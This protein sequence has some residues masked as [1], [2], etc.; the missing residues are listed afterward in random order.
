MKTNLIT[1][2]FL[3]MSLSHIAQ[4][5][6]WDIIKKRLKEVYLQNPNNDSITNYLNKLNVNGTFTDINYSSSNTQLKD[7]AYNLHVK[8]TKEL[9]MAYLNQNNEYYTNDSLKKAYNKA[10]EY[11]MDIGYLPKNNWYNHIGYPT[12]V[13]IGHLLIGDY[14]YTEMPELYGKIVDYLNWRYERRAIRY[15][16]ATDVL[17]TIEIHIPHIVIDKNTF[18]LN[19]LI[20]EIL[21]QIEIADPNKKWEVKYLGGKRTY[22]RNSGIEADYSFSAHNRFGRQTYHSGYGIQYI[23]SLSNFFYFFDG[24]SYQLPEWA[25]NNFSKYLVY[26]YS[27]AFHNKVNDNST[28]GRGITRN[29]GISSPFQP[30]NYLKTSP[31]LKSKLQSLVNRMK[32]G[33]T[34]SD[35]L[36]G[37]KFFWRT[38]RMVQRN[39]DFHCSVKMSSKRTV[40]PESGNNEGI[41]NYYAGSGVT[42]LMRRGNEYAN[43]YAY[44]FNPRKFPGT[45]VEQNTRALPLV[46]W[47]EGGNNG[48]DFSGGASNNENGLCGMI[49]KKKGVKAYK[50]WFMFKDEILALGAGIEQK[51]GTHNVVTTINQSQKFE[52]ISYKKENGSMEKLGNN[53]VNGSKENNIQ[54]VFHDNIAYFPASKNQPIKLSQSFQTKQVYGVNRSLNLFSLEIDHGVNPQSQSYAYIIKPNIALSEVDDFESP[55]KILKNDTKIQAVYHTERNILQAVFY[56]SGELIIPQWNNITLKVNEPTFM[57]LERDQVNKSLF[58]TGSNPYGENS[59]VTNK[60]I[61]LNDIYLNG[62]KTTINDRGTTLIIDGQEGI[63]AGASS[64]I[65]KYSYCV[66]ILASESRKK[67]IPSNTRDNNLKTRWTAKGIGQHITFS[68]CNNEPQDIDYVDIAFHKGH[69]NQ[70][71][72]DLLVSHD[73]V[74]WIKVLENIKSNG[75]TKNKERFYFKSVKANYIRFYGRGNSVNKLNSITEFDWGNSKAIQRKS[76]VH[77][78]QPLFDNEL[79]VFPNPVVGNTVNI[80]DSEGIKQ[81]EIYNNTGVLIRKIKVESNR[82]NIEIDVKDILFLPNCYL[83]VIT[84]SGK[85][86]FAQIYKY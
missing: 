7:K 85:I 50:S 63:W 66:P 6:D 26:G 42:N 13:A 71:Y 31:P 77:Q 56:S 30:I 45:T 59:E 11:F 10:I 82:K 2:A 3:L 19:T 52:D 41:N 61:T 18:R 4:T 36:K 16:H 78:I 76:K 64:S 47:G 75:K 17:N 37:N 9:A 69:K 49:H 38:D 51:N 53:P 79:T 12:A 35:H 39:K 67:N 24:T 54:W 60:K 84:G 83:R 34:E 25:Y 15:S 55:F 43:Y 72:F 73:G 33:E 23:K 65:K 40:G 46:D 27:W 62:Y 32:N 21:L 1:I 74:K 81:V 14:T 28:I 5:N 68:F 29:R 86:K 48:S 80:K 70:A 57:M 8:R 58:I 20:E 44:F 22:N